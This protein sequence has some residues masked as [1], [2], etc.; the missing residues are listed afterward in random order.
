[1]TRAIPKRLLCHTARVFS[2]SASDG[3]AGSYEEPYTISYVRFDATET[4]SIAPQADGALPQGTLFIDAVNSEPAQA[5][6]TGDKVAVLFQGKVIAE[7]SVS[8]V[9]TFF[10]VDSIHHWEVSI[11][12]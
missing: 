10:S 9:R 6:R 11:S 1:M 3:F 5:P 4:R 2:K 12:G 7:G 8:A